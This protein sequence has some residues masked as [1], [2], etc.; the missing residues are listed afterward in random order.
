MAKAMMPTATKNAMA[1]MGFPLGVWV[2]VAS[3]AGATR[4]VQ[5]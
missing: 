3:D 4:R 1:D 2:G 5:P